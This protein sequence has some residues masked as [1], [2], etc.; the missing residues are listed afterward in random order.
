MANINE[1]DAFIT[2]GTLRDQVVG[3]NLEN[4]L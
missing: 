3:E 4:Q 1:T 2:V